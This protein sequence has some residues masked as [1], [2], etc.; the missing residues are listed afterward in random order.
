MG[1]TMTEMTKNPEIFW[2]AK[3]IGGFLG[4]SPRA[5]FHL[6]EKGQIPSRKI[7]RQWVSTRRQLI[8]ALASAPSNEGER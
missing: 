5:T 7:G 6:L 4:K 3:A 1:K 8:E 2:G